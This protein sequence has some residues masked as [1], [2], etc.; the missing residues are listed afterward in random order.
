MA[1]A[2]SEEALLD[3]LQQVDEVQALEA[4]YG[5]DF[6]ILECSIGGGTLD[7]AAQCS[8][9]GCTNSQRQQEPADAASL[10]LVEAPACASWALDCSLMVQMAPPGG[11]LRLQLQ[12]AS[13]SGGGGVEGGSGGSPAE[14][15]SPSSS[16]GGSVG[17]SVQYLPPICMQLRLAAGYPGQRAP[18]VS[19]SALW[20]SGSQVAALEQQLLALWQEQGP[21]GPVCY[22]WADWLQCSALQHLGAAETLVLADEPATSSSS[23]GST[24]EQAAAG[25][26]GDEAEGLAEDKLIKLL[27]WVGGGLWLRVLR[28]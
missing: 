25:A 9:S 28:Y 6:R 20:L 5:D 22:T 8:S 10:A 13:G 23:S 1:A 17:Y 15:G 27:R 4:I 7:D 19:L 26:A 11:S 21:G 24:V 14:A 3:W 12:E 18:E 2:L 16:G